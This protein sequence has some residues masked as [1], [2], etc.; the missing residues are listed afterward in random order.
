MCLMSY[1]SVSRENDLLIV[2]EMI[3]LGKFCE[4]LDVWGRFV[5]PDFALMIED[6]NQVVMGM[7]SMLY[8]RLSYLGCFIGLKFK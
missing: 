2:N 4:T 7:N 3:S 1:E 8:V 6:I 5:T